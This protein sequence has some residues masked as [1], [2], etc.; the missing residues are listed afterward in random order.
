MGN[1]IVG[2]NFWI[3]RKKLVNT[4]KNMIQNGDRTDPSCNV[5]I[6]EQ[7]KVYKPER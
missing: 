2:G 5:V 3:I 4:N 6:P 1:V 7:I